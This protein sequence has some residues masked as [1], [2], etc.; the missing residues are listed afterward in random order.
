[1]YSLK[2]FSD[3]C[4]FIRMM[5]VTFTYIVILKNKNSSKFNTHAS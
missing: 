3:K 1:M 5:Y 4:I 2:I